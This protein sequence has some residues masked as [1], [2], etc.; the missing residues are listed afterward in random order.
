LK[1]IDPSIGKWFLALF[2]LNIFDIFIT[3]PAYEANPVTLYL[4]GRIGIFLS[5]W[6]K[7]GVVLLLGGVCQITRMVA[8][9]TDWVLSR[10][11]LRGVLI[12]LVAF[13]A[14]VAVWNG[15]IF[16]LVNFQASR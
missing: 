16:G 15:I 12:A 11:L 8:T 13:Y 9:P 1:W 3:T 2:L 5:A 7:I 10:K 4:W 6:L 14:F